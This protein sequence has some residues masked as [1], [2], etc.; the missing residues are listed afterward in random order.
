MPLEKH[1]VRAI[2]MVWA[3]EEVIETNF[4]KCGG[5][6]KRG[7]VPADGAVLFVG[8]NHHSHGI[9]ANKAADAALEITVAGVSGLIANG[10]GVQVGGCD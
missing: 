7:D 5:T 4:V 10:N 8:A 6:G 1:H 3:F 2:G 9:P